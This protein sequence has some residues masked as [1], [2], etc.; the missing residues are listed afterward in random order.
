MK[1]LFFKDNILKLIESS[2]KKDANDTYSQKMVVPDDYNLYIKF[3]DASDSELAKYREKTFDEITSD[4]TFSD[5]RAVTFPKIEDQL[6]M[7]YW[8][9]INSTEK[10]KETIGSVKKTH[11]KPE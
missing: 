11:P 6:D 8:D 3:E 1:Y 7:I 2:D 5:K 9:K 4:L 10:W